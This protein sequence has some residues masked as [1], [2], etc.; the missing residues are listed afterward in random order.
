MHASNE[1]QSDLVGRG[2]VKR[3]EESEPA[4]ISNFSFLVRLSAVK[5]QWSKSVKGKKTVN[6]LFLM[7]SNEIP[8]E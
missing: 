4:L 5:Y 8:M 6:L 3:C 1:E 7:K 2:L